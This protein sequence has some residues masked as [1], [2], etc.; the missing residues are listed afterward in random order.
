MPYHA[1]NE[2]MVA[3]KTEATNV[4]I[5]GGKKPS[6]KNIVETSR[7]VNIIQKRSCLVTM[8]MHEIT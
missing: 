3:K 8:S 4:V 5:G 1:R 7:C 6:A 2:Q